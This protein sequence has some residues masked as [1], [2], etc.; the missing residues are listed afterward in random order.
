MLGLQKE[1]VARRRDATHL[2]KGELGGDFVLS[3]PDCH[4]PCHPHDAGD[5]RML[6]PAVNDEC[7]W[8][9]GQPIPAP[10][11]HRPPAGG[12]TGIPPVLIGGRIQG[13]HTYT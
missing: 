4:C 1:L 11:G 13:Y 10:I 12:G 9:S 7:Y 3:A 5:A 8:M 6:L 2:N